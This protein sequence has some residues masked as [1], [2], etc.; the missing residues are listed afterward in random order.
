MKFENKRLQDLTLK[1]MRDLTENHFQFKSWLSSSLP[2][3]DDEVVRI[4]TVKCDK[5]ILW[6]QKITNLN[7]DDLLL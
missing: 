2:A 5:F 6:V 3:R 4:S 1:G 7:V